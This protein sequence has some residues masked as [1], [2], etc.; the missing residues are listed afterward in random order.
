MLAKLALYTLIAIEA[1]PVEAEVDVSS[2]AMP[3][4]LLVGLA[5]AGGTGGLSTRAPQDPG[6]W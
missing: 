5:A 1:A 3:E 4:T 2:S 6:H